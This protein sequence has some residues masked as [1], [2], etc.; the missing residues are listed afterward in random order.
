[1][2]KMMERITISRRQMET[3]MNPGEKGRKNG[4]ETIVPMITSE[5]EVAEDNLEVIGEWGEVVPTI[6]EVVVEV[7]LV[8]ATETVVEGIVGTR[9][10]VVKGEEVAA[11]G[12]GIVVVEEEEEGDEDTIKKT[13]R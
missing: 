3:E 9:L 8:M 11:L 7:V 12:T 4:F 10:E 1:M 5:E 13:W 6:E 2:R